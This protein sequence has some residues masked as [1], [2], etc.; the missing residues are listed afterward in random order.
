MLI[1]LLKR[2]T[3]NVTMSINMPGQGCLDCYNRNGDVGKRN[4]QTIECLPKFQPKSFGCNFPS[5]CSRK[6][7]QR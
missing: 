2:P 6:L 3:T 5:S 1:A 4:H 7:T